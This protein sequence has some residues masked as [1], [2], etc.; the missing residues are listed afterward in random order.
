APVRRTR[1]KRQG[2]PS[3]GV[4]VVLL[5]ISLACLAVSVYMLIEEKRK[6]SETSEMERKLEEMK[7][8]SP[9]AEVFN[10]GDPEPKKKVVPT[11]V[12]KAKPL[13]PPHQTAPQPAPEPIEVD[14][15]PMVRSTT[16]A[17]PAPRPPAPPSKPAAPPTPPESRTSDVVRRAER[18]V[19]PAPATQLDIAAWQIR[20]ERH[21]F[22][23]G[24]IDGDYGMRSRRAVTQFQ[25]HHGLPVTGELDY[26][27]RYKLGMPG[28]PFQLYTVTDDD[29]RKI[30]PPP[31]TWL[32]K[33]KASYLGYHDGWEMLAEKFSS[34]ESFLQKLNPGITEISAGTTITAPQL[35]PAMPLP[36][37]DLIR[38]ILPETTLLTYKNGKVMSCFPCS[39]AQDKNK[40]PAGRLEVKN[41]APNPN[42]TFS[43]ALFAEAAEA[44]GIEQRL[45]IPP[46]PNN[47]V[48]SAWIGLTLP[49]YGIHGTTEP[50]EIS[51]TGS[52][53]CFR[54][55]NWNATKLIHMVTV[56]VP[57]EIIE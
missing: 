45:I 16:Q 24:T 4:L 19:G 31:V 26:E 3:P 28:N 56:G 33:S 14:L 11:D 22:S 5:L 13:I 12:V 37:I 2:S 7:R 41:R 8:I 32:E 34:T 6:G 15:K 39:I 51:R 49:G 25:K 29:I 40:R 30:Q 35:E 17:P 20:L 18:V 54:L 44:E 47:P 50:T 53:G 42:Y 52:S 9:D 46:G 27:T 1:S 48:G 36:K 57:V 10:L 38:I 43:P 23:M 21:H 55:A